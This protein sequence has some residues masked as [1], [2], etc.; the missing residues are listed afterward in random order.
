MAG[1]ERRKSTWRGRSTCIISRC[2]YD[3]RMW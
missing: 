1:V 3:T 2:L